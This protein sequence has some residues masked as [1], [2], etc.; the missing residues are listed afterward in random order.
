MNTPH[1]PGPWYIGD[2]GESRANTRSV[3]GAD[4]HK[5]CTVES[6]PSATT[7]KADARLIAAAPELLAALRNAQEVIQQ[8][9]GGNA[10]FLG[11]PSKG[12][13]NVTEDI[14]AA[15]AKATGSTL[16]LEPP[17]L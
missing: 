2:R 8:L 13:I 4:G 5:V 1:T 7:G 17:I 3:I 11:Q 9:G 16:N 12:G 15:I 10:A 14:A 6:Y